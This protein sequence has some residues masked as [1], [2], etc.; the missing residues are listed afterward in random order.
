MKLYSDL[1]HNLTIIQS[2]AEINYEIVDEYAK[3]MNAGTDFDPAEAI[4]VPEENHYYVYNGAHRLAAVLKTNTGL[5]VSFENG[6]QADA[7]WLA[8]SANAKHGLRRSRADKQRVTRNALLMRPD[9]S[10]RKIAEHCQVDH[11]TVGRI[12]TDLVASGEIPQIDERTVTRNGKTFT[13]KPKSDFVEQIEQASEAKEPTACAGCGIPNP[14]LSWDAD[15]DEMLLYTLCKSCHNKATTCSTCDT[16]KPGAANW[17]RGADNEP[18]CL[19]CWREAQAQT[20]AR[21]CTQCG[22]N[23]GT[24]P[25]WAFCRQTGKTLCLPCYRAETEPTPTAKTDDDSFPLFPGCSKC[26]ATEPGGGYWQLHSRET[27]GALCRDCS[28]EEQ[29]VKANAKPEANVAWHLT[30]LTCLNCGEQTIQHEHGG[31]AIHCST[32]GE[33]WDCVADFERETAAYEERA[34]E[35]E[36]KPETATCARCDVTDLSSTKWLYGTNRETLCHPC[37]T[38]WN[39]EET[40]K[41]AEAKATAAAEANR[42]PTCDPKTFNAT[43][44]A[45]ERAQDICPDCLRAIGLAVIQEANKNGSDPPGQIEA[46]DMRLALKQRM[47]DLIWA[48]PSENLATFETWLQSV[49]TMM[50]PTEEAEQTINATNPVA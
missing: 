21:A 3:M 14:G 44:W 35:A 41:I 1:K 15:D 38:E 33:T 9:L 5:Y 31:L 6:T 34:A 4:Y 26:G 43:A 49:E 40:Q 19:S 27:N 48:I 16:T 8:L 23:Q 45:K 24:N 2:R 39:K 20:E 30:E 22:T 28:R 10:D 18:L 47:R 7:E 32:C 50:T 17:L 37:W 12:R 13:Q 46:A 36:A 25:Q 29:R 42:C 11:K